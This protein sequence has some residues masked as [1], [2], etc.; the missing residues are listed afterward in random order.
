MGILEDL[1]IR[2]KDVRTR[3]TPK[4]FGELKFE[5]WLWILDRTGGDGDGTFSN[6]ATGRATTE[7]QYQKGTGKQT[8]AGSDCQT[9]SLND[10]AATRLNG[11]V[12]T[13]FYKDSP[14]GKSSA[15]T[16]A[17]QIRIEY[18]G[19]VNV[20]VRRVYCK[21]KKKWGW[22]IW[23]K[24][25]GTAIRKRDY[26]ADE[27]GK[28][29]R[30]TRMVEEQIIA[31]RKAKAGGF[32]EASS[33]DWGKW[34]GAAKKNVKCDKCFAPKNYP[35]VNDTGI[36]K[37]IYI[38]DKGKPMSPAQASELK[39][40][41]GMNAEVR[42]L[43]TNAHRVRVETYLEKK[44]GLVEIPQSIAGYTG[45]F[46][47]ETARRPPTDTEKERYLINKMNGSQIERYEELEEQESY[48]LQDVEAIQNQKQIV[49]YEKWIEYGV[50]DDGEIREE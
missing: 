16:E 41:R 30:K 7:K 45:K 18:E 15:N 44:K 31:P 11:F 8:I 13:N 14:S 28:M 50:V 4:T 49:K 1:G 3:S 32:S 26:W 6:K 36:E 29:T 5:D 34:R 46:V 10:T 38:N 43:R 47:E 21:D 20:Q 27:D 19:E 9:D 12:R 2:R 17:D 35:C 33:R 24:P 39:E 40:G 42:R 25:T 22:S 48:S 23:V 37:G